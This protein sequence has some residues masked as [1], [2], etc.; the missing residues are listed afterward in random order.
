MVTRRWG[1]PA[2][3]A[4]GGGPGS[5]SR[6]A[7]TVA[8]PHHASEPSTYSTLGY[9]TVRLLERG[10]YRYAAGNVLAIGASW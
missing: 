5:V 1:V 7:I 8:P 3:I 10:A 6:Y 9:E 4:L 2:A